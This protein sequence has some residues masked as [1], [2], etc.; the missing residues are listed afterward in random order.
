MNPIHIFK[1]AVTVNDDCDA[2]VINIADYMEARIEQG[3]ILH[4]MQVEEQGT[5]S[6]SKA[7]IEMK[8]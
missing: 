8:G 2:S 4:V 1:I 3:N 5:I 6:T 7:T